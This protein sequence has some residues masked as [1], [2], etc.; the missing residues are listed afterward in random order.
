MYK[1]IFMDFSKMPVFG[2]SLREVRRVY[3]ANRFAGD[4]GNAGE[5][6]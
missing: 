5:V 3:S 2:L 6:G 4:L 1:F